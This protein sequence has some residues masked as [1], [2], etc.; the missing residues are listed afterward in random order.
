MSEDDYADHLV[1]AAKMA[2]R[3]GMSKEQYISAASIFWDSWHA[4]NDMLQEKETPNE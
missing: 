4:I 1:L 3:D 2:S